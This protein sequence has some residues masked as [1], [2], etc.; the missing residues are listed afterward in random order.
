MQGLR[1]LGGRVPSSFAMSG[2][3][4]SSGG[5]GRG[6]VGL[7]LGRSNGVPADAS[8]ATAEE[9]RRSGVGTTR[10]AGASKKRAQK[11]ADAGGKERGTLGKAPVPLAGAQ[12]HLS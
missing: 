4:F 1:W 3:P 7:P 9:R 5:G 12:S 8:G 11:R 10:E 2:F 6:R